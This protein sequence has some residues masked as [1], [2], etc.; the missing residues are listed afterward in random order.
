MRHFRSSLYF[1]IGAIIIIVELIILLL[2]GSVYINLFSN[3]I[4][5]RSQERANL[6]GHL[7]QRSILRLVSIGDS[8]SMRQI[9]GED[10]SATMLVDKNLNIVYSLNSA[11][12]KQPV[13]DVTV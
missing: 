5:L 12:N 10:L 9:V 7:V 3:Q 13:S 8:T 11:Y 2:L 6:P 4:D 1:K